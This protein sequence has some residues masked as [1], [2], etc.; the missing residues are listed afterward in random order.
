[1]TR[2][3]PLSLALLLP[4]QTLASPGPVTDITLQ[5]AN[6]FGPHDGQNITA[7]YRATTAST[8]QSTKIWLNVDCTTHAKNL[9]ITEVATGTPHEVRAFGA[10]SINRYVPGVALSAEGEAMFSGNA[11]LDVCGLKL[12]PPAWRIL[13]AAD[14]E[15]DWQAVDVNNSIR[16]GDILR[17]RFG[18]D[19][20][21]IHRDAKYGAPYSMKIQD[22][23][24]YCQSGNGTPLNAYWLDE[25]DRLTLQQAPSSDVTPLTEDQLAAGK[26]LCAVKDIRQFNGQG[27]LTTREKTL[28]ANQ[29]TPPD[30][31]GNDPALL[32]EATLPQEVEK[33]VQQ[34]IGSPEQRPAFRHLRY[35][36]NADSSMPTIFRIDTQPDGTTLTLKTAPLANIAFYFQ[37]QSLFNL[38]EL[39]S[40]ESMAVTPAV[41]QTL[42]S[43]IA[44]PPVAGGH[45]QWRVQQQVAKKAQ[46]VT[47]SQTCKA[48]AQWQEAATLNPRFS[49]R[50][51]E[52]TC[53]DDRG[54]GR[55]M[56]SDYA[57]LETLRIF[58]RIGYHE[59]GKKVRFALSDVEIEQ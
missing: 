38:V 28:A 41:T 36:Q 20:G 44:L 50:L 21:Q 43:D 6:A 27:P 52:F 23:R 8:P 26:A 39:K 35:K 53:T 45:F 22:I 2:L 58:I 48:D 40:V 5:S 17:L 4:L 13:S 3:T 18:T 16:D 31:S 55:A 51:L 33:R 56:S 12:P 57:W 34:A 14:K 19:Y 46:Q 30:F 9:L 7:L 42:E 24:F 54:D 32:G 1:M 15:G 37:D 11:E 10:G 29:P 49:G 47:K 25:H 59:E